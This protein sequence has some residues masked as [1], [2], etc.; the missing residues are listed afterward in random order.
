[1]PL[2]KD[3]RTQIKKLAKARNHAH[4]PDHV[5]DQALDIAASA[6]EK[7]QPKDTKILIEPS[8][9]R[10]DKDKHDQTLIVVI[11]KDRPFLI[12]SVTAACVAAGYAIEGVLHNTLL[13]ERTKSGEL[14]SL[15]VKTGREDSGLPRESFLTITLEG[16]LGKDRTE[17]LREYLQDIVHDVDFATRDWQP[18]REKVREAMEGLDQIDKA[19]DLE[20]MD[21]YKEFL[22][23]LYDNNFTLLGYREYDLSQKG[24]TITSKIVK[25]SGLGL[26]S[27]SKRP[28]YLNKTR[29]HL[30]DELQ[31][32]RIEQPT[33][34][35]A[36]INKRATVH[37]RVPMD[38]IAV[39]CYDKK[40]KV[41]GE[42]LFIG[43]FTSVTYSRSI[44]DIPLL[45]AKVNKVLERSGYGYNSHNYRALVHILEKYPRDELFQIDVDLLQKYV[46]SIMALQEQPKVA[47]YVREDP[48]RRYVSCLVYTPRE[49]Y[50][51]DMRLRMQNI[52][53]K[54]FGGEC[55]TFHTVLDDSPLA[56]V[57]FRITLPEDSLNKKFDYKKIEQ[58]IIES[59]KTWNERVRQVLLDHCETEREA[60]RLSEKYEDAF[61]AGYQE[62]SIA[63]DA[64]Y[65][66]RKLE[67][68]EDTGCFALDLYQQKGA[69]DHQLN[70]KIYNPDNPVT[71]SGILPILENFGF[72]VIAEKPFRIE[73]GDGNVV[74]IHDFEIEF[75][76]DAHARPVK[77]IKQ[78]FE[79]G[80]RAIW[81]G[82]S[83]DDCLNALVAMA[84]MPWR[85]VLVL[86]A[87]IKYM[88]QTGI[89]YTPAYMMQAL[90]DYPDI[91]DLFLEYFYARHK[92]DHSESKRAELMGSYKKKIIK[93]LLDVPSFDQDRI[94][95][96]I[97]Q[98]MES[99]LRTNYFQNK[100]HVSYKLDSQAIDI[101]PKP[102]PCVEIFVYSPRVEGVHLRGG[103]VARGGLRWS[104][105]HEDFRTEVLG[106]MKAQNVKNSVIIPVGS[107]GGFV[108][109]HPP[110]GG[111]RDAVKAEGVACYKIFIAGLLD[112]TDNIKGKKVIPPKDVVRHDEDDP[113]LVVAADKGTAT[114]SDIANGLSEDYGFWLG[115][116]FASGGSAGYDHKEMAITARG[117]WESVKRHFRELGKNIQEEPFDVIGVGDMSGDVFGNGMLLSPCIRLIGAFNHLHI[118]CDPDPDIEASFKERERLFKDGKGW[119]HYDESL[120]SKGGKIFSR[121][122]KLLKL[123]PQ[124]QERF[125]ITDKEVSPQDLMHAMLKAN[126]DLLWFGGIGTYIKAPGESHADV[127]DKA[128]DAIR[129]DTPDV[130]AKVIGE[131]ANLGITH[132]A[133]IFM[134]LRGI[135]VYADFIDNSGGVNSSDL[136][137]NIKILLKQV[138]QDTGMTVKQRNTILAKMTDDVAALVLRNNYLQTQGISTAVYNAYEKL[139]RHMALIEHLEN[140]FGLDRAI[141]HLPSNSILEERTRNHQGL[142]APELAT[143]ISFTKIK[144]FQE[145]LD[146]NIPDDPAFQDW[147]T[148]YFPD[149]LKKKYADTM[150]SHRLRREII[151]TQLANSIVNRMGPSYILNQM[152]RTGAPACTI[153]RVY[154]LV[155]EIFNLRD[156]YY[157][158]EA[159]DNKASAEAQIK[160]LDHIAS[161]VDY[162]TTWF[163]KHYR[164]DS[165]KEKTLIETGRQYKEGVSTILDSIEKLLPHSAKTFIEDNQ[166]R[167][168]QAG[169]TENV[170]R[171]IAMLPLLNAVCDIVHISKRENQDIITV[172]KV[173]FGLSESLSFVWLRDVAR[174]LKPE[175]RWEAETLK[176]VVNRL[177]VTQ[178]ELTKRVIHETCQGKTCPAHPVDDWIEVNKGAIDPIMDVIGKLR[179]AEHPD[180]A[181]L[182]AIEVSLEQLL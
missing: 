2:Y 42:K 24:K 17:A 32:K 87:Y 126:T 99:T 64:F 148:E 31:K 147:M 124:I 55:E 15:K 144:L 97:L 169:F 179:E 151:A 19:P 106:L 181:M 69:A 162:I 182:T 5:L 127:G 107:K 13:A 22:H 54:A 150:K 122:D 143:L 109:K 48:F 95:R 57:I 56:R 40:G 7:R 9:K 74:W 14:K 28:V 153:A 77:D 131:G 114:F 113:Y 136:E 91:A 156:L 12:D 119:D 149:L 78:V 89:Q 33:L 47:L 11:T 90:T 51:T 110:V 1:M 105:R 6:L 137:V 139:P 96:S 167:Y 171:Q 142:V 20:M 50:E 108:V 10:N 166:D 174:E 66:I 8:T 52:L 160:A 120:L 35:I 41:K 128:N 170:A 180:F 23:Y 76:N 152:S 104:D 45:R 132:K 138:M 172:A 84:N 37:R 112:I 145:L 173:Y 83:E 70:L 177:Y 4:V 46:V 140:T 68:A 27:D 21:E 98:L 49:K 161:L 43:L 103:K 117:A 129:V 146:S 29:N 154:F 71:L 168:M 102:R 134:A 176:G 38:A 130:S 72:K 3:F 86:R 115:D 30:P 135:K 39:K 67:E 53:V 101:L 18:M 81:D 79:E 36:K 92:P 93:Q 62:E 73:W 175:S 158:I 80:L 116:A 165:L 60:L 100:T 65:D 88:R 59:A 16:I 164:I 111:D 141:E 58:K 163:L 125:G 157:D 34:T 94:L 133:R 123:T 63:M 82:E 155:R 61:P 75:K 26:L 44:Q 178:A 159:M 121:K 118:F 25:G 85:D